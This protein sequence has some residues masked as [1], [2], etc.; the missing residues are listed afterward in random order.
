LLGNDGDDP[1]P[2]LLIM[3]GG[4]H[5]ESVLALAD[6]ERAVHRYWFR[7]WAARG[8]LWALDDQVASRDVVDALRTGLGDPA[9]RVREMSAKVIARHALGDLFGAVA[10]LHDDPVPR[11][12][13]AADRAVEA[14]SRRDA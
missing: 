12:R 14:L 10:A 8:L 5:A 3:L 13:A 2:G 7:V 6:E 9:W 1:D 11:V 4:P